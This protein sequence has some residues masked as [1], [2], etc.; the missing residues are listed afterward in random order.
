[1]KY[2]LVALFSA[3]CCLALAVGCQGQTAEPA[4]RYAAGSYQA[5]ATGYGGTL[6]VTVEFSQDQLLAVSVSAPAETPGIGLEAAEQ[7]ASDITAAQTWSVDGIS[8]A[9]VT[10]DAVKRAVKT[11]MEQAAA[12]A[13]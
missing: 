6:T 8:Q 13:R 4:S 1:M 3:A 10:S 9:T 5:E 7:L 12:A 2:K 11:C